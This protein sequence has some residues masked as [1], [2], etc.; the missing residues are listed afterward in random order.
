MHHLKIHLKLKCQ[1]NYLANCQI[2]VDF[3]WTGK[4]MEEGVQINMKESLFRRDMLGV[5]ILKTP[6]F[7]NHTL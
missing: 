7:P 5:N 4:K 6:V 1:C 3:G 2:W